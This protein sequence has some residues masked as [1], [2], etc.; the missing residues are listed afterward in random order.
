[1][2]KPNVNCIG[3]I[4]DIQNRGDLTLITDPLEVEHIQN[5]IGY[6]APDED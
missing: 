3:T 4:K 2:L 6:L 1:M 5:Y